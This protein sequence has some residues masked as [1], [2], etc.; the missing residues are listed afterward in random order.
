MAE[1]RAEA[2]IGP[3]NRDCLSRMALAAGSRESASGSEGGILRL[4]PK[5][6]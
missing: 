2:V 1:T 5:R 6:Y 4:G 3:N